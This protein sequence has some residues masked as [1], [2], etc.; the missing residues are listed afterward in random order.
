M[1]FLGA[2]D[3]SRN[4]CWLVQAAFAGNTEQVKRLIENGISSNAADYDGRTAL[5]IILIITV[6]SIFIAKHLYPL[7]LYDVV[8]HNT[9][10]DIVKESLFFIFSTF[11]R[12]RAT[13][14]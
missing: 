3:L 9:I 13:K 8:M 10:K 12:L 4:V 7:C 11:H 6:K 14:K 1:C 2:I 5:V